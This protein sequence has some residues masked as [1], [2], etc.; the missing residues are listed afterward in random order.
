MEWKNLMEVL[1]SYAQS[2]EE[3][4]R[5]Q[6]LDNSYASGRLFDSVRSI[7]QV[8]ENYIVVF[9]NLE[10]YWKYLEDGRAPGRF[11]PVDRIRE[12]IRVKPIVPYPDSRGRVPSPD[13]LAFL[14]GRSIAENGIEGKHLLENPCHTVGLHASGDQNDQQI[15]RDVFLQPVDRFLLLVEALLQCVHLVLDRLGLCVEVLD[16]RADVIER[17]CHRRD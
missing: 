4:Y 9:L 8:D 2:L 5:G 6:V 14:I 13:Q 17:P 15:L 7:I 11:P 1:T 16:I 12:W 3:A 10:D